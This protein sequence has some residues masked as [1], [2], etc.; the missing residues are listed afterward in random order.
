MTVGIVTVITAIRPAWLSCSH[1]TFCIDGEVGAQSPRAC[2][3]PLWSEGVTPLSV[4]Q[5]FRAATLDRV[6]LISNSFL[7]QCLAE[8]GLIRAD[9]VLN[10]ARSMTWSWSYRKSFVVQ[11]TCVTIW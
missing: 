8:T 3:T 1:E 4:R 6:V 10:I 5:L 11:L 9:P 7:V 2:G